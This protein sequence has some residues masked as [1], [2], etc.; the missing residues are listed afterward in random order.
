[1]KIFGVTGWKNAGKTGLMERL[2]REITT[3]GFSVSTVKHAHHS[4]DVDHPGKDSARHRDA[5]AR[6]VLLSS[7]N[8][9]ALMSELR[10]E[11]EEVLS[12][13]LARL[14]PVDLVLIEGY[15]RDRHP[16]IEA[17][18]AIT[19][20]P[21][22]SVEDDSIVALASDVA[23][24]ESVIPVF[25]LDDTVGIADFVLQQVGLSVSQAKP[26]KAEMPL[27]NDCF[28]LPPGVD[29]TPVDKAL[30]HLRENLGRCVGIETRPVSESLGKVLAEDQI[31]RRSNPP[32]PNSA[33]DGYGFAYTALLG[34]QSQKLP[35]VDGR[36]AA[37]SPYS[38]EVPLGQA[39]RI[40]TGAILPKGVDTVVLQED[41]TV[42]GLNVTFEG[43]VKAG[44]NTR[45]AGEDVK[46]GDAAIG[47]GHVLRPPDLALLSA[48]GIDSVSV[49]GVLRV[50]VISTGDE[51]VPPG[52]TADVASTYDANRPMLLSLAERWGYQPVDLGHVGDNRALLR[53][54]LDAS[55][56]KCDVIL[57]SGGA[58]AGDEDH[59]SALLKEAGGLQMW[60]IAMKPG[61]PL[62]L[63]LWRGVPVF[64]LP[65]NP[66]AAFVCALIFARPA[67]GV[68]SGTAWQNPVGFEVSA[69]FEKRKKAG[70]REYLRARINDHGKAEVFASEGSGRISGLTWAD[71]LVEL[72]DGARHVKPGDLVRFIPYGAFGL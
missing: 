24:A 54:A 33:V 22:I 44:A 20:H 66:V 3:R 19:K 61:R 52:S 70:R 16:K 56:Q 36:A 67:C 43:S 26:T 13:L 5:G 4:F 46:Q 7:R 35:L 23:L 38:A 42:T 68:L 29:W 18:R 49:F 58:S 15:K 50:G 32:A 60:R 9:W 10:G 48:L 53:D 62:A 1:M 11:D 25:D 27:K 2:V 8:R 51:L 72:E 71:G 6:E 37:G 39:V 45:K 63:G 64:G 21:L 40:L 28:A 12:D 69:S 55:A 41:V 17:H 30:A 57:T 14:S 34:K 47:A 31:A 59:M 65:G